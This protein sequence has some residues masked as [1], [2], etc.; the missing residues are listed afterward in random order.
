MMGQQWLGYKKWNLL[1]FFSFNFS[2]IKSVSCT[3]CCW[4]QNILREIKSKPMLLMRWLL[5]VTKTSGT[6]ALSMQDKRVLVFH[7]EGFNHLCHLRLEKLKKMGIYFCVY[8][9]KFSTTGLISMG[10]CNKDVTLL[11]MHW[12]YIFLALT[13]RCKNCIST[14]IRWQLLL[15]TKSPG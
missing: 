12:S 14:T 1:V 9:N 2:Y 8:W 13:Y 3:F 4:N 10:Y 5:C 15:N 6:M 11:L 7:G